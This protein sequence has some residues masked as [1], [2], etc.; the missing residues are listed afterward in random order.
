M[1]PYYDKQ[2]YDVGKLEWQTVSQIVQDTFY[3]DQNLK[4]Q[5]NDYLKQLLH[6]Y[7]D[8]YMHTNFDLQRGPIICFDQPWFLET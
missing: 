5:L 6:W 1:Y 8:G 2:V 7:K 3:H 4:Q